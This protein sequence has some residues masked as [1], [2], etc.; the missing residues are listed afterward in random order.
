MRDQYRL[1]RAT[2]YQVMRRLPHYRT[3]EAASPH[4][5]TRKSA[6]YLLMGKALHFG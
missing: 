2:S 3:W 1:E 4:F 6:V 5:Y